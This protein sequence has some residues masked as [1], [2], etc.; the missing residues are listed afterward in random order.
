MAFEDAQRLVHVA[1]IVIMDVVVGR[2]E[3]EMTRAVWVEFYTAYV[4]FGLERRN[5]VL[6]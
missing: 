6:E 5:G 1:Q 3:C 4:R 2:T